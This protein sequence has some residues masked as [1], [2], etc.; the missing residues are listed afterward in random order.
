[1]IFLGNS[2]VSKPHR[3]DSPI[4]LRN[5]NSWV[6]TDSRG[7]YEEQES[8]L[9]CTSIDGYSDLERYVD[10]LELRIRQLERR[11]GQK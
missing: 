6:C 3:P 4:C 5:S 10:A 1:M 7:D 8:N 11:C 2:C 9:I